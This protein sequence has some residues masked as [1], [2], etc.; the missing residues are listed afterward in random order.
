MAIEWLQGG[1][2]KLGSEGRGKISWEGR[3]EGGG[4]SDE[5]IYHCRSR[6]VTREQVPQEH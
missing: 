6:M 4:L 1:G 2:A 5:D 3:R